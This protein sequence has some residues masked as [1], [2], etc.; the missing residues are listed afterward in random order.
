M[1]GVKHS[2][3][4]GIN[5]VQQPLKSVLCYAYSTYSLFSNRS[6]RF[7]G[8][9]AEYQSVLVVPSNSLGENWDVTVQQAST[10][11]F[12]IHYSPV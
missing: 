10:D 11:S 12:Q 8:I 6:F 1:L 3:K 9:L 5:V 2:L 4:I 7:L